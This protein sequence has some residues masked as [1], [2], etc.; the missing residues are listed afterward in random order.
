M[1]EAAAVTEDR[2]L[3]GRVTLRQPASGF[4]AAIDP[5]LLAAA[6]PANDGDTVLDLGTGTGAAA[7]CLAARVPGC[8][9]VGL[10]RST[11]A[12]ALATENVDLN[13]LA[14]RLAMVLGDVLRPP[15]RLAPSSFDHVMANP[16]HLSAGKAAP[17]PDAG[18]A[19][20]AVEGEAALGDWIKTGL[21]MLRE[22]GSLTMIHRA[23]RLD[24][25]LVLCRG[26]AGDAHVVPLWPKADGRP[27]K[28]V[29]LR[30]RKGN[31]APLKLTPGVVLH[32]ADG[33]YTAAAE[34]ILRDG[35]ALVP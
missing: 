24:E 20:A 2:L 31:A 17:S 34:A 18:R 8:R 21:M 35:A 23:D 25:I 22:G 33:R 11:E 3:D 5:V 19:A 29:I 6:V 1:A 10:E 12:F 13:G 4:R 32:E 30:C 16:P 9:V 7:L 27:A 26:R 14:D 15:P 28:R